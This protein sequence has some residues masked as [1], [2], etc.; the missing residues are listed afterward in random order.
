M[1]VD[2]DAKV[3]LTLK[4]AGLAL[5]RTIDAAVAARV[6]QLVL[7]GEPASGSAHALS[8]NDV[9]RGPRL[10]FREFLDRVQPKSNSEKI[11]AFAGYLRDHVG[12]EDASKDEIKACFRTAGDS[13]PG[14]F[15]RDFQNTVQS[16]WIAEDPAKPGRFYLTRKGEEFVS[17]R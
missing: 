16:G 1:A 13:L 14:N 15:H 8:S 12:Q 17:R 6:I 2:E 11:A 9:Y 7:H 10:S 5:E 3:K 4:G